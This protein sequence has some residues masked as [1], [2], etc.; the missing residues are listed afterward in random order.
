MGEIGE[1]DGAIESFVGIVVSESD[2]KFD[3][4]QKLPLFAGGDHLVDRFLQKVTI[5]LAHE[6]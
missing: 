2:L 4:L 6:T 5:D 1:P 3:G